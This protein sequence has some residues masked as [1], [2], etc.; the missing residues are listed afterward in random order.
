[1]TR[2]NVLVEGTDST[3]PEILMADAVIHIGENSP[4]YV[5]YN[6]S[7][8]VAQNATSIGAPSLPA[9]PAVG[10]SCCL[11]R[12][13]ADS[14]GH[15]Q[16]NRPL[17][18]NPVRGRPRAGFSTPRETWEKPGC[19]EESL[20]RQERVASWKTRAGEQTADGTNCI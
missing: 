7:A 1:M 2:G 14:F 15:A 6:L 18:K 3:Q 16:Q 10:P 13:G 19:L 20:S 4:E 17:T 5:A 12:A 11:P 9:L 8:G